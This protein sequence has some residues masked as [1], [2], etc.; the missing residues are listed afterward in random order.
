MI[1]GRNPNLPPGTPICHY[2][3]V[4]T[5]RMDTP[6]YERMG[7]WYQ[8]CVDCGQALYQRDTQPTKSGE[9]YRTSDGK[10]VT[11]A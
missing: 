2:D 11:I 1:L 4:H 8:D 5:H 7:R 10:L 3:G 9:V 6:Y